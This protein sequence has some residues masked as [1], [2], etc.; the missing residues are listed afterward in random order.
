MITPG[1]GHLYNGKLR[2]AIVI[3][4][5]FLMLSAVIIVAGLI[6]I[7]AFLV[8]LVLLLIA[9]YLY[10]TIHSIILAR[11]NFSYQIKN[12]NKFIIYILWP[13]LFF[14]VGLIISVSNPVRAFNVPSYGMMNTI[15]QGDMILADMNYY[16]TNIV[17]RNDIVIFDDPVYPDR[18]I[19]KRAIAFAGETI[20]IINGQ[21]FINGK[22]LEENNPNIIYETGNYFF[23][24]EMKIPHGYIF[25]IGDNRPESLHSRMIGPVP[26]NNVRGK[27]IY[28]Y[29]SSSFDRIG[30]RLK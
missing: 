26:Q 25:F 27:P 13:I 11:R 5:I 2:L 30:I 19:I 15:M 24:D 10:S 29:F 7:F 18:L 16:E 3:P 28:I 21:I 8:I 23:L 20:S 12:Y 22:L 1:L 6:K 14:G 4:A 17:N 9:V